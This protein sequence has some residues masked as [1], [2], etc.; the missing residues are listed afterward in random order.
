MATPTV[1]MFSGQGSQYFQ[2]GK[3]MYDKNPTF[4]H[5]MNRMD[6]VMRALTGRSVLAT[7][8]GPNGK[9]DAF[10]E[11]AMSHPAVFMVEYAMARTLMDSGVKPDYLLGASLGSFV[12]ACVAGCLSVEDALGLIVSQVRALQAHSEAGGMV[13]ILAEQSLFDQVAWRSKAVV[14]SR[15]FASHFVVSARAAD[16]PEIE[17]DLRARNVTF[18]TLPVPYPFHSPWIG[19]AREAL[20]AGAA[21]LR[22]APATIP[23]VC[24]SVMHP[25]CELPPGFFWNVALSCIE[26]EKT[27]LNLE[28][29]AGP[30]RYIDVGPAGTLSTF[31]KYLLPPSSQSKPF[32]TMNPFGR[33]LDNVN[34]LLPRETA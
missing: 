12:A 5:W 2:M 4:A 29:S 28:A 9:G 22:M 20:L 32:A 24:C 31:V 19:G 34:A 16:L 14:A 26:F 27:L 21:H 13:A 1:F 15:N 10:S 8:Y 25:L 11:L 18:Q 17:R 30:C 6:A 33:D 7:L 3:P 23:V